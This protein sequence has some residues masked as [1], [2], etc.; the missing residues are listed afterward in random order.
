MTLE[1]VWQLLIGAALLVFPGYAAISILR[2]RIDFGPI[3]ELCLALGL[4]IG[5]V[6]LAL[7][8]S[9]LV[10]LVLTP[11]WAASMPAAA[12]LA[13]AGR[14]RHRWLDWR[15]N[16]TGKLPAAGLALGLIFLGSL[17]A[18]LLAVKGIAYPLWTDSYHHTM[19]AQLIV[20]TGRVPSS[21]EPYAPIHD[22]TYH[23]GF[24]ALVAWFHWLTGV[25]VPRSVVVVGQVVNALVV[26]TTY[27][28]GW[29][30]FQDR[31]AGLVA[32]FITGLIS[33]MPALFVN[34]GRYTQLSGQ[35]LLPAVIV[36]TLETL[37]RQ[38]PDTRTGILAG[39]SLA[40][41]FLVHNR[42]TL[43]FLVFAGLYTLARFPSSS[44]SHPRK[45]L[46]VGVGYIAITA[47]VVDGPWIWRFFSGF[48]GNVLRQLV[49]GYQ[50]QAFG[51]YFDWQLV[52]FV[53]HGARLDLWILAG[54]GASWGLI[55][56][57][58]SVWLLLLWT[59]CLLIAANVNLIGITPL[60]STLIVIIWLY[61]PISLLIGYL[62]SRA[63]LLV[64][65]RTTI[66]VRN[67][68]ALISVAVVGLS[69]LGIAQVRYI[70]GLT[71]PQNGFVREADLKAMRWIDR[72]VPAD[73][74]FDI[75]AF[76]WTPL[77]AHGLD[78][79]YWLPLLVRR[80]TIIPPEPY[81]GDGSSDYIAYVNSRIRALNDLSDP[82]HLWNAMKGYGVTHIYVGSRP[83]DWDPEFLLQDP[84]HFELLY[85]E[86]GVWV[87]KAAGS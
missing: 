76:F 64:K 43:F 18:R 68:P 87:F 24:H 66:G 32:A 86:E 55:R 51:A 33:H 58:K 22:F 13:S 49:S 9:T 72:Y 48:G 38:E 50:A 83:T 1:G 80:E 85:A 45:A 54:A 84:K 11:A 56:R 59:L 16:Q 75:K 14:I 35:I 12:A 69:L 39:L 30:L 61:L 57:D 67:Y 6:P 78:A 25:P 10:G 2:P 15:A 7:Y 20:D 79:G 23:F 19:I 26:P 46:L 63:Y 31:L 60:F 44:T 41:L 81:A 5:I 74:L 29:R 62:F 3:E 21:F 47:L 77:V 8:V 65:T 42:I 70:A 71:E 73:A 27:L 36:L 82:A 37:E 28:M 53:D 40:G 17:V 34:W 4:S 52:Q